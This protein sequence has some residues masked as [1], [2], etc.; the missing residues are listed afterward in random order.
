M[1]KYYKVF[2]LYNADIGY[3]YVVSLNI[4]IRTE[5]YRKITIEK[6]KS[7]D[8]EINKSMYFILKEIK[9]IEEMTEIQIHVSEENQK[10]NKIKIIFEI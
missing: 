1:K 9:S 2:L 6:V 7:L 4:V 10:Y 3:D 8:L 5:D